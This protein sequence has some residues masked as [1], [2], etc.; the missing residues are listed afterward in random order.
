MRKIITAGLAILLLACFVTVS[1]SPG[2]VADPL[3]TQSHL[4]GTFRNSL[5]AG[6]EAPLE[7]VFNEALSRLNEIYIRHAGYEFAPRFSP[8]SLSQGYTLNLTTGSSFIL[9]SGSATISVSYGE[10]ID[11]S[12][13]REVQSGY[14][15]TQNRR[16]F[17]TENTTAVI[18]AT[19]AVTGQVDGFFNTNDGT[20]RPPQQPP[21]TTGLPFNDVRQNDWF[22]NAVSF[23]FEKGFFAGTSENTFSPASSM[24]RGMFVT[25]LHRLEGEPRINAANLFSDVQ[26]SGRWYHTAVTWANANNIVTGFE[27]G[28][29]RP[30]APVTR[31]Q[32]A[33]IMHRY[34]SFRAYGMSFD[35]AAL[36]RFPDAGSVSGFALEPM[37]WAVTQ[38]V[39]QGSDGRLLPL[40]TAT[41]AQV[42]QIIYNFYHNVIN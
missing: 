6:V 21:T 29:F 24:T 33:T 16:Y 20:V 3:V 22:F 13:G 23:V 25:V 32:M 40:N 10:V 39:I 8:V 12:N 28:T 41:R 18:T 15:L 26:D 42:A 17:V 2:S 19:S 4:R 38:A 34:A 30:D 11:I 37:R 35:S 1:A 5:R 9:L 31:E 7:D 14:A 36:D 27:D